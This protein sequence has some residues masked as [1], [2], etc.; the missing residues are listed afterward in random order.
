VCAG[1][2]VD[3]A[4]PERVWKSLAQ[5]RKDIGNGL[6]PRPLPR[7][8]KDASFYDLKKNF[9]QKK[10]DFLEFLSVLN[11]EL[12]H[13]KR[14]FAIALREEVRLEIKRLGGSDE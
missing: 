11:Y 6:N 10:Q 8:F 2:G 13:R 9:N 12:E 4:K 14:P 5:Q 7:P 1:K 3:M